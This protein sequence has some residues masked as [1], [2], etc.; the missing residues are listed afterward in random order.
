MGKLFW[1]GVGLCVW[2]L[3]LWLCGFV[4]IWVFVVWWLV[5]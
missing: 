5:V 3:L 1:W 4:V 2:L